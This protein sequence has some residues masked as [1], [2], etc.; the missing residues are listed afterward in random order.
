MSAADE[1]GP[2]G[3]TTLKGRKKMDGKTIA[4]LI[5][6]GAA[7]LGF[8]LSPLS[9]HLISSILEFIRPAT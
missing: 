5:I 4:A 8:T 3:A 7:A 6:G 2:E 9:I 1:G